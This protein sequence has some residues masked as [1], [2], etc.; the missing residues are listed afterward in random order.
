MTWSKIWLGSLKGLRFGP[1]VS[2]EVFCGATRLVSS[3]SFGVAVMTKMFSPTVLVM[4]ASLLMACDGSDAPVAL[5]PELCPELRAFDIIDS[6]NTDTASPNFPPLALNPYLDDG[7]Y[8]VFWDVV[9]FE[10]YTVNLRI[11]E[12]GSIGGSILISSQVCGAGRRCDQAGH[13][14][15]E[16]TSDFYMSCNDFSDKVDIAPLIRQVPQQAFLFIEI[17]DTNSGDCCEYDYYPVTLE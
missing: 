1:D 14:I 4:I 16:Y 9:S 13:W 17:C 7:R 15:C 5:V 6:Y 8:E 12:R 3:I 10:D 11:N 2:V